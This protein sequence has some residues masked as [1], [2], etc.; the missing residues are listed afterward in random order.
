MTVEELRK[1]IA[2]GETLCVEFKSDQKRLND[3]E[4]VEAVVAMANTDGGILLLGVEDDGTITGLHRNHL[5]DVPPTATIANLT[6]P[7]LPVQVEDIQD[8]NLHVFAIH[9]PSVSGVTATKSGLYLRRRLKPDGKP[10][11]VPMHPFELQSRTSRFR[12]ADPSAQAMTEVPLSAIDPLQRERLRA[13]IRSN[14]HSDKTLLALDDA[15]FDRSLGLVQDY[16]GKEYLSLAGVLCLTD[17]ATIRRHVPTYEVAFQVLK[18]LNVVVNDFMRKPLVETFDAIVAR[19][20]ARIEEEETMINGYRVAAPNYDSTAFREALANAFVHRDYAILETVL[21][22]FD[23]YGLTLHNPGGFVDGVRLDNILSVAPKSRNALLADI[24]KRIGIAERTG[25][26]VDR[27]YEGTLRY[28]RHK[29]GYERSDA[30][31]VTV[32]FPLEKA[33]FNFLDMVNQ[34]EKRKGAEMKVDA[35]LTLSSLK[36]RGELQLGEIVSFTQRKPETVRAEIAEWMA[37][38][39][40]VPTSDGTEDTYVLSD[41]IRGKIGGILVRHDY[42]TMEYWESVLDVIKRQG[43]CKRADVMAACHISGPQAYK[44]L[45]EMSE[46]SKIVKRGKGKGTFYILPKSSNQGA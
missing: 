13:A 27:I 33:D 4:L 21:V 9:V 30:A 2:G 8:G 36:T 28:G 7:A 23:D 25:R 46:A 35:L 11:T 19:F 15:S 12:L 41:D 20:A 40:I 37:D 31:G 3:K 44:V 39:L 1:I 14:N 29:P 24:A 42:G 6:V 26:G 16:G 17:E 38:G 10:E 22:Q 45:S 18:G 43:L 5:G 34:Y 32:T